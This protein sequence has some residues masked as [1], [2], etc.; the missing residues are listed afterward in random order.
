MKLQ[1]AYASE[2]N[3]YGTWKSIGYVA[4]GAAAAGSSGQTTNF[5]YSGAIT[6]DDDVT[7]ANATEGWLANNR[8]ALNDCAIGKG[9]WTIKLTAQA[10]GNSLKYAASTGCSEL[11]PSFE[12]IG[13]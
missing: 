9:D 12:K 8:V 1:D 2:A 4:P 10:N 5:D 3:K 11:T 7:K 6:A 13:Q